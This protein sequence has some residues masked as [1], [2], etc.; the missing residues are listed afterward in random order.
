MK[1]GL[2]FRITLAAF[3]ALVVFGGLVCSPAVSGEPGVVYVA[4]PDPNVAEIEEALRADLSALEG[5]PNEVVVVKE[6]VG[7]EPIPVYI[8]N[9]EPT[10]MQ[11]S[12]NIF[13]EILKFPV[14]LVS[15]GFRV[16]ASTGSTVGASAGSGVNQI[17][18]VPAETGEK[19]VAPQ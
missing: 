14:K 11:K 3:A 19:I 10:L 16:I 5:N 18:T 7:V 13:L 12:G 8:V 17:A 4:S 15:T 6:R 9:G 2:G 1:T